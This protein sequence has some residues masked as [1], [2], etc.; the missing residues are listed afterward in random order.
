MAHA[1]IRE[2][3]FHAFSQ[4]LLLYYKKPSESGTYITTLKSS[5][6]LTGRQKTYIKIHNVNFLSSFIK[7]TFFKTL[8][9]YINKQK[10]YDF[11]R[12]LK[13]VSGSA[14]R[15]KRLV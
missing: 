13:S 14:F 15:N 4:R 1:G 12:Y 8:K 9:F 7:R 10:A 2:L 11:E 5:V 6:A 3:P